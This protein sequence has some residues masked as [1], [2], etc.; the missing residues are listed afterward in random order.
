MYISPSYQFTRPS[1][2]TQYAGNDLVANST[3]A[4]SVTPLRFNCERI[5]GR[6]RLFGAKMWKSTSTVTAAKFNLHLYTQAPVPTNGDN[7]AYAVATTKWWLATIGMDMSSGDETVTSVD[8]AQYFALTNPVTFDLES[9]GQSDGLVSAGKVFSL[10]GLLEMQT[11]ATY[12]PG[13]GDIFRATLSI[14][15]GPY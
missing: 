4:G 7:G 8:I 1:D 3:T 15:G 10:F 13:S 11:G 2:T 14:E 9:D 5:H 12:T 6:G